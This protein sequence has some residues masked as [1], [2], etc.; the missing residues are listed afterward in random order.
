MLL[1]LSML[2]RQLALLVKV[3]NLIKLS[4]SVHVLSLTYLLVHFSADHLCPVATWIQSTTLPMNGD[5]K[6]MFACAEDPGDNRTSDFG[7]LEYPYLDEN[8]C[9]LPLASTGSYDKPCGYVVADSLHHKYYHPWIRAVGGQPL[10]PLRRVWKGCFSRYPYLHTVVYFVST[11]Y[12]YFCRK[13]ATTTVVPYLYYTSWDSVYITN[14]EL[15]W[16]CERTVGPRWGRNKRRT[17]WATHLPSH[18]CWTTA[19]SSPVSSW[20]NEKSVY[21]D[22]S[23]LSTRPFIL[24]C[25]YWYNIPFYMRTYIRPSG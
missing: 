16:I 9:N 12:H 3:K 24:W 10:P 7:Y 13:S 21:E 5:E 19:Q 8:H 15:K 22:C 2:H 25:S 11:L 14:Q 4:C 23:P 6:T 20:A 18:I 17:E 1:P